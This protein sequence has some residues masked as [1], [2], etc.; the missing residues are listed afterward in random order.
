MESVCTRRAALRAAPHPHASTGMVSSVLCTT[1]VPGFD[2][3]AGGVVLVSHHLISSPLSQAASFHPDH[4][5]IL[6][7]PPTTPYQSTSTDDA[8]LGGRRRRK[9][10]KV[11]AEAATPADWAGEREKE[12]KLS[13]ADR[14]TRAHHS[15]IEPSVASAIGAVRDEW[16][17]SGAAGWLGEV[18]D[19]VIWTE[20]D[21]EATSKEIDWIAAQKGVGEGAPLKLDAC[22]AVGRVALCECVARLVFAPP[23]ALHTLNISIPGRSSTEV[24]DPG[25]THATLVLPPSSAF[26]MADFSA[27]SA[28]SSGI[29]ATGSDRGGWDLLLLE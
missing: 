6:D 29:A 3:D 14:E 28:P 8:E 25:D 5:I 12:A 17:S 9:R 26:L 23:A 10:R 15:E 24:A 27:W 22:D 1:S 11:D 13:V 19:A 2:P 20:R 18:K 16:G 4:C 21:R 7:R